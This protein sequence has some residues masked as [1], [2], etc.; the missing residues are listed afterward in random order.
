MGSKCR[1]IKSPPSGGNQTEDKIMKYS[2][3][4]MDIK[5]K[6]Q[7][8]K[9]NRENILGLIGG[10]VILCLYAYVQNLDVQTCLQHGIC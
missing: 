3:S 5:R 9:L 8:K 7:R 6:E 2:L 1:L 4:Y 10:A